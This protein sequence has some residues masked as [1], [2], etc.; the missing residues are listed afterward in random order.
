MKLIKAIVSAVVL[1]VT[2]VAF[3]IAYMKFMDL[4]E[5]HVWPWMDKVLYRAWKYVYN[6]WYQWRNRK[7]T[8]ELRRMY[9]M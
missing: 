7:H 6:A 4:L 2:A 1:F 5:F 8:A 3:L 9:E